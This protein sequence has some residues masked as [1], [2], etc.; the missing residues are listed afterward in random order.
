MLFLITYF[1]YPVVFS[2]PVKQ[3]HLCASCGGNSNAVINTY[4]LYMCV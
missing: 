2:T 3:H 4:T 1:F